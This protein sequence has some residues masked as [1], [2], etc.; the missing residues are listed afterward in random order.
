MRFAVYLLTV[1]AVFSVL[2][3]VSCSSD[4]GKVLSGE[5]LFSLDYGKMEDQIDLYQDPG[6]PFTRKT[7]VFMRDGIFYIANGNSNKVMEFTSYGDILSLYYNES[8][9]P[10]TFLL[11]RGDGDGQVSNRKVYVHPFREVGEVAVTSRE[12]LLVEDKV[13]ERQAEFDEEIGAMLNRVVLRF[14]REGNF[15]DYLGQEGVGGTPFPFIHNIHV[16]NSDEIVVVTRS[17]RHWVVFW[18]SPNGALLYR[19]SLSVE[20]L[21]VPEG[22]NLVPSLS[23]VSVDLDERIMYLKIEYYGNGDRISPEGEDT[24]KLIRDIHYRRSLIW[25]FDVREERFTGNVEVPVKRIEEKISDFDEAKDIHRIYD[26][27]GTAGRNTFFLL[28]PHSSDVFELLLLRRNGSVIAR[29]RIKIEEEN[30]HY[31]DMY[32]TS[33]GVLTALLAKNQEVEIVWWRSDRLLEVPN[34]DNTTGPNG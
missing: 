20:N 4:T 11:D 1:L 10:D 15:L 26:Y 9:N 21:P 5:V 29:R 34:E 23:E 22:E 8:E 27:I 32:V 3:L 12:E 16:T 7:R 30:I 19:I 24:G 2:S 28:A 13:G 33:E 31:R 14:D 17:I 25:F 18:F 6:V